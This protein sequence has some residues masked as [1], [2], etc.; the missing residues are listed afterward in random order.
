MKPPSL[1]YF[2]NFVGLYWP[3]GLMV[4]TFAWVNGFSRVLV[5]L[6]F[7]SSWMYIFWWALTPLFYEFLVT[8]ISYWYLIFPYVL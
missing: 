8:F 2:I 7:D 1:S 3:G 5:S 6:V 4:S